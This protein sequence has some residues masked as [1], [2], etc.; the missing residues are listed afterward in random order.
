M[1]TRNLYMVV[2]NDNLELPSVIGTAEDMMKF[3]CVKRSRFYELL[4][5]ETSDKLP[6]LVFKLDDIGKFEGNIC[7]QH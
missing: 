7:T 3:L 6:F 2:E 5:L 1:K 4:K